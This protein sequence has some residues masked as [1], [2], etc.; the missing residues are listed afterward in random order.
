MLS[1]ASASLQ[2]WN[3]NDGIGFTSYKRSIIPGK[4]LENHWSLADWRFYV[5]IQVWKVWA[6]AVAQPYTTTSEV[7][8]WIDL[9]FEIFKFWKIN[10]GPNVGLKTWTLILLPSFWI[11]CSRFRLGCP[12]SGHSAITFVK[13]PETIEFFAC[14]WIWLFHM[15]YQKTGLNS[16]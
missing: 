5:L 1:L 9:Y 4:I 2:D 3:S 16:A 12:R 10:F 13:R 7:K 11:W 6:K 8:C 15:T 14:V